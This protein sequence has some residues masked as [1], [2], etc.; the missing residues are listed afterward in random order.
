[1]SESKAKR[2]WLKPIVV[3]VM[4]GAFVVWFIFWADRRMNTMPLTVEQAYAR[5]GPIRMPTPDDEATQQLVDTCESLFPLPSINDSLP[6]G[7]EWRD[8][9]V[10]RSIFIGDVNKGRWSPESRINLR[11]CIRAFNFQV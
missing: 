8:G 3:P 4:M 1:M 7:M 5:Y 10:G 9:P 2:Q 11:A 6:P